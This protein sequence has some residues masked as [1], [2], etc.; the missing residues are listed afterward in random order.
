MND[1]EKDMTAAGTT[2]YTIL[3]DLK[4]EFGITQATGPAALA[5]HSA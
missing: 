3:A 1:V 4:E 5:A 2:G